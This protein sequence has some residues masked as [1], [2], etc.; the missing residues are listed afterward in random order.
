MA[1][2]KPTPA[3]RHKATAP[4][5]VA[6][7][8][9]SG[10]AMDIIPKNRVRPSATSRPVIATSTPAV[11]DNTMTTP[12]G[13]PALQIKRRQITIRPSA[14]SDLNKEDVMPNVAAASVAEE[15]A[16]V[17]AQGVSVSELLAK[18]KE[19]TLHTAADEPTPTAT[20]ELEVSE[21][22]EVAVDTSG[23]TP[24]LPEPEAQEEDPATAEAARL[25]AD[26]PADEQP[27]IEE[28]IELPVPDLQTAD[29]PKVEVEPEALVPEVTTV[30]APPI[31]EPASSEESAKAAEETEAP[32]TAALA[33]DANPSAAEEAK[34][35]EAATSDSV[36]D[37]LKEEQPQTQEHSQALKDE[38]KG[39]DAKGGEQHHS[40][41]DGKPVIVIHKEHGPMSAVTWV[42]WFIVC[43]GLALLIVNFLLDADFITTNYKIPHTNIL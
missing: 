18:R 38:I 37:I 1:T 2:K 22:A 33:A 30:D 4:K 29:E 10:R 41:Y 32:M 39:M 25:L 8:P 7:R 31:E 13:A 34:P 28:T 23:T 11:A 42:L 36:E 15:Q 9:V 21:T 17:A 3:P 14:D 19:K 12:S 6:A 24:E 27:V 5:R 26:A 35:T 16:P 43:V 20:P 40:S